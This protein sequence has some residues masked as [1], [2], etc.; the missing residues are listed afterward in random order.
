MKRENVN[1]LLV[2]SFVLL[3]GAVLL[4]GL[5]R[6]TGNTAKGDVYYTHFPNVAGIKVGTVV[7]FEGFE[8]GNV[9]ELVPVVREKRTWYKVTLNIRQPLALPKDSLAMIATPGLLSPPL[10]EIKEGS[11][12]EL[13]ATGGE[14]AGVATKNVMESVANLSNDLGQ[15]AETSVKP[16]LA[17]ISKRVE[18]VGS[19]LEENVPGVMSDMRSTMARLN[20][21]S[22]RV[23]ALFSPENQK[24]LGGMLKNGNEASAS[25]LKLSQELQV[26]R[27]EVEDLIKDSH[28]LVNSNGKDLQL[29]LRRAD[30]VL[31]QLESA[32]RNL[33]EFSRSIRDNPA[34]LVQGRPPVDVAGEAK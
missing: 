19:S 33:N 14:L 30:A 13:L 15:L 3:M 29:S 18:T 2:G 7:T 32:G 31:Y 27:S 9:T 6:I 16:L 22:A 17:Q 12:S 23:E 34:A 4:Y 20:T 28:E 21:T 1:Y 25:V 8:V 5:Y 26:V 24:N 11:S 10:V